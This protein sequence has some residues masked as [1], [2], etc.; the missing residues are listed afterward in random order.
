MPVRSAR[1]LF[2]PA[3]GE[4]EQ[5]R[6]VIGFGVAP[7]ASTER[8]TVDVACSPTG[9]ANPMTAH[10]PDFYRLL[11]E[12][13]DHIRAAKWHRKVKRPRPAR[14]IPAI[15]GELDRGRTSTLDR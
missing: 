5:T 8:A 13:S 4:A 2:S 6:R 11:K 14:D 15:P 7:L 10:T 12:H 3:E 1:A 9:L